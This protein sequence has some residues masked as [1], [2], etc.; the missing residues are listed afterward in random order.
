MD[1]ACSPGHGTAVPTVAI[2]GVHCAAGR[3][4]VRLLDADPEV[5]R[6]LAI[7]PIR[8]EEHPPKLELVEADPAVDEV[9]AALEGVD[10]LAILDASLDAVR[11]L[12][13]AAGSTGIRTVAIVTSATVYGAWADNPVPLTEDAPLRPNPGFGFAAERAEVE[14]LAVEWRDDHPGTTVALLRPALVLSADAE[15]DVTQRLGRMPRVPITDTRPP[16]Q[17][18]HAGD[19]AGAVLHALRHRLDGAYNVAP[20][21]WVPGDTAGALGLGGFS[22]PLPR[23]IARLVRRR[24]VVDPYLAQPWVVAN[25]RLRATGWR[26][27][28]TNEEAVVAT[29]RGSWWRELSP[30]RKQEMALGASGG[31]GALAL[32]AAALV[33]R[34]RRRA[35]R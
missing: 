35:G 16:M 7:D 5:D 13:D 21:G 28:Y 6:L 34:A 31:V 32:A 29:R 24:D 30:K 19:L 2:T 10:Q 15:D 14:R 18:L 27:D 23:R 33:V 25:D 3:H 26:P 4:V 22:L 1:R 17:L 8:P 11:R 12:L 20:D 9:K